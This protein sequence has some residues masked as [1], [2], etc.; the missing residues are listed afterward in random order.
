M[1]RGKFCI[2]LA[3]IGAVLTAMNLHFYADSGHA[4]NAVSASVSAVAIAVCLICL[5]KMP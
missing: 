1:N 5:A 3:L 2:I 4:L